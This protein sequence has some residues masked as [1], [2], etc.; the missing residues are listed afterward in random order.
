MAEKT[1]ID[2]K[3]YYIYNDGTLVPELKHEASVKKLRSAMTEEAR[4]KSRHKRNLTIGHI[5]RHIDKYI[6]M[7][8]I[9]DSP[10]N[11][12]AKKK[13]GLPLNEEIT[14]RYVI[15]TA[16]MA[17]LLETRSMQ[18]AS[19]LLKLDADQVKK[20]EVIWRRQFDLR[21]QRW[22]HLMKGRTVN[23]E[24]IE[25]EYGNAKV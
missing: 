23:T 18:A 22:R 2:G 11:D 21:E 16:C 4:A 15:W 17:E 8:E 19:I 1:I 14:W 7:E 6:K 3:T 5:K 13:L 10:C 20:N 25:S 12:L 24:V 9:M